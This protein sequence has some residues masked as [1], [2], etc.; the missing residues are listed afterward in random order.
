MH[1]CLLLFLPIFFASL[2]LSA[3]IVVK[4]ITLVSKNCNL[5]SYSK[6]PFHPHPISDSAAGL[7]TPDFALC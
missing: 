4:Y 7:C 2:I 6:T 5:L 1:N 3:L